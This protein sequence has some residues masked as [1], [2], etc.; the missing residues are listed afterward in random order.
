MS[1][2]IVCRSGVRLLGEYLEGTLPSDVRAAVDRHVRG[3]RR[4]QGFVRSYAAVPRILRAA[5]D[6]PMPA[7]VTRRLR[8]RLAPVMAGRG[9]TRP[10]RRRPSR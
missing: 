5:T 10:R 4:C 7:A 2:A 8:R 1:A 6:V 3:C 9:R